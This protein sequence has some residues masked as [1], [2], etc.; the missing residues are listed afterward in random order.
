VSVYEIV[1]VDAF[2]RVA[3]SGNPCAVLPKATGLTDE[4]MQA[5]SREV[6]LPESVFVFPSEQADFRVRIFTP[7]VEIP[8]AGHPTIAAGFVLA[9]EKALPLTEPITRMELEFSIGVLP[10]DIHVENAQPTRIVLTQQPPRFLGRIEAKEVAPCFALEVS[11]LRS[12]CPPQ[13]VSTGVPFLVVPVCD[14]E[15]LGRVQMKRDLLADL[16]DRNGV[17]AAFMFCLGGFRPG[18]DTH[19]RLFDPR[20][21]IEDPFT[22]SATGAMGAYV[23]HYGLRPGPTIVA[24]QGHYVG[25]PG[26]GILEIVDA[27]NGVET[28]KLG[29]TAVRVLEGLIFVE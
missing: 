23:I 7:R 20:S 13:V 18:V 28:V 12:D 22:G 11:D 15:V 16:C 19:A 3:F 25:R 24:E 6:N 14:L 29:G 2:T 9:Y 17:S 26:E 1:Y 27:Q 8:F 4:Q 10:V 21:L 5:I